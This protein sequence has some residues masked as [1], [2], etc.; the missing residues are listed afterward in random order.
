M[1]KRIG[2]ILLL[3]VPTILGLFAALV[4]AQPTADNIGVANHRGNQGTYLLVPVNIT[5]A[6]NGPIVSL[7]LDVLYDNNIITFVSAEQ[8]SLTSFWDSPNTNNFAE[9]THVSIVYDGKDE[10]AIQN[11]AF[12]SFLVLNFSVIGG[13]GKRSRMDFTN[14]QLAEGPPNYN[15]GTVPA[16]NGTFTI[17]SGLSEV[18][19]TPVPIHSPMP[20]AAESSSGESEGKGSATAAPDDTE[21]I[22]PTPVPTIISSP[23]SPPITPAPSTIAIPSSTA[24]PSPT[25]NSVGFDAIFAIVGLL[26]VAYLVQRRKKA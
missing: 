3:L 22:V 17:S 1:E 26:V 9:G 24:T 16:R 18:S 7:S 14:I 10:H 23:I 6:Q 2:L 20:A 11:G 21:Y 4:F 15:T 12:G 19:A 25:V 8:V 5:N 13:P